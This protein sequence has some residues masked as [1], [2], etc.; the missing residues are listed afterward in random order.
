MPYVAL[1]PGHPRDPAGR[2]E[3]RA[4]TRILAARP[5]LEP[6]RRPPA[7]AARPGRRPR[8][9]ARA[10]PAAPAVAAAALPGRQARARHP[11]A[12]RRADSAARAR[13]DAGAPE[14]CDELAR[15]GAGEAADHIQAAIVET[16]DGRRLAADGLASAAIRRRFAPAPTHRGPVAR[17]RLAGR[18]TRRQPVRACAAAASCCR[19][20]AASRRS[21]R[22]SPRGTTATARR[23][24]RGRRS[25]RSHASHRVLRCSFCALAWELPTLRVHL[26]RRGRRARSSP[27]APDR[28]RTIAASKSAAA[29][30]AI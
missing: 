14:L 30:A 25:P 15:G 5:D 8:R 16:A 9:R 1:R 3:P 23:A 29:A 22:R 6:A 28:E 21:P 12:R 24:A 4:G 10:R 18:R 27:P 11:G 19:Q 17:S 20:R 7:R 13:P 2:G 26:L